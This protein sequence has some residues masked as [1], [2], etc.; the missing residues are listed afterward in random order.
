M[1]KVSQKKVWIDYLNNK[2]KFSVKFKTFQDI[3]NASFIL[4]KDDMR[5][6]YPNGLCFVDKE[7]IVQYHESFGTT[8]RPTSN[9]L[10][11][12]DLDNYSNQIL[13]SPV[14][15][16]EKDT[17]LIRFPY[18]LSTPAHIFHRAVQHVGGTVIPCSSR[19]K[20]SP[21]KR[22]LKLLDDLEPTLIGCLPT[23]I[24]ELGAAAEY[25]GYN[26]KKF[27]LRAICTAGEVLTPSMVSIIEDKWGVPV[28]NFFGSTEAGNV[29][30]SCSYGNLHLAED[31]FE[32]TVLGNDEL[33]GEMILTTKSKE[34]FPLLKYKTEDYI[35]ISKNLCLCGHPHKTFIHHGRVA[36]NFNFNNKEYTEWQ[37]KELIFNFIHKEGLKPFWNLNIKERNLY[38]EGF[39]KDKTDS[40]KLIKKYNLSFL[41][42]IKA[43]D[44]DSD[45]D[46]INN[47]EL[48]ESVGKPKYFTN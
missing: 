29:A 5:N 27:K 42:C 9:W 4:T 19:C 10:T 41:N 21:Y 3:D 22:V 15:I 46:R 31:H 43:K 26:P 23:E 35:S 8:G 36:N 33:N 16:T 47:W 17:F 1:H 37:L 18:A 2:D 24:M 13:L 32:I 28:Y 38:I 30:W 45:N 40:K 12:E 39:K 25:F 11:K 44:I 34:A 7:K 14:N 6:N 48:I 20:V